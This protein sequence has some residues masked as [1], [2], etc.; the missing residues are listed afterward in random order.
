VNVLAQRA[1]PRVFAQNSS[2]PA[3]YVY[4]SLPQASEII[5]VDSEAALRSPTSTLWT[6]PSP[7]Q[8]RRSSS[9]HI[10]L[11]PTLP[12]AFSVPATDRS[13][14]PAE[15]RDTESSLYYTASWGSPYQR[16]QRS[17]I[18]RSGSER[19]H[20]GTLSS[21]GI[22][23]GTPARRLDFDVL[24]SYEPLHIDG[25]VPEAVTGSRSRVFPS[26]TLPLVSA[27]SQTVA[28][29]SIRGFT[30]EWIRQYLSGQH[31]TERGNWWSDDSAEGEDEPLPARETLSGPTP[32]DGEGWLGFDADDHLGGEPE[33]PTL[34]GQGSKSKAAAAPGENYRRHKSQRSNETL[35]QTDFWEFLHETRER[36]RKSD[37]MVLASR[38]ADSP[39]P[40]AAKEPKLPQAVKSPEV[41]V[42]T[43]PATAEKPLPPAPKGDTDSSPI[44]QNTS[45]SAVAR[46][47][48]S[49][50]DSIDQRP[51]KRVL[52][53]NRAVLISI[54][55]DERRGKD[56]GALRPLTATEVNERL[57][58]WEQNGFDTRGFRVLG[59]DD[60]QSRLIFPDPEEISFEWK[61]KGELR[62]SIPDRRGILP[63][64]SFSDHMLLYF[65]LMAL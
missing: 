43:S 7:R 14:S 26:Q 52:W 28:K 1:N 12:L 10:P 40:P 2:P 15:H 50:P 4:E 59:S 41:V 16:P 17:T 19:R 38:Y 64:F 32:D 45:S 47:A 51:K 56:G 34:R 60:G 25:T 44:K 11:L 18:S 58:K 9:P 46:K 55:Y 48:M 63:R 49:S 57:K 5:E 22:S 54:P 23:E 65:V 42:K 61:T 6:A 21:D 53:G 24:R 20:R 35:K 27:V 62:V 37:N 3:V 8:A 30:E 13:S 39:P 31:N 33:T 29:R 36:P